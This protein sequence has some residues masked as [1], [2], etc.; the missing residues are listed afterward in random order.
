MNSGGH[1]VPAVANLL[2]TRSKSCSYGDAI[3]ISV[4]TVGIVSGFI[5]FYTQGPYYPSFAI[6]NTYG[7]QA[8]DP[9]VAASAVQNLT[10]L[11][12]CMDLVEAC[13]ALTPN[14]YR[15]QYG[16][17]DTVTEACGVAFAYCWTNVYFA[18][19]ALSG[20]SCLPQNQGHIE[21]ECSLTDRDMQ[22]DPFDIA[23]QN[24]TSFPPPYAY[25]FLTQEWVQTA[26][27]AEVNY[28]QNS[29]PTANGKFVPGPTYR[30]DLL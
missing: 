13:H 3:P 15:D 27:G 23:H 30:P 20:V 8:Y 5:D 4:D 17:N 1:Y 19:D 7:I 24:P 21:S 28:T 29:N 16:T 2:Q 11:G 18:Y 9:E 26:L 12:G 10:A 14:G 25:G 6:N 22:R